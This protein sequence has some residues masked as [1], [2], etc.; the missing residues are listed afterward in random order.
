MLL[1]L[2][3]DAGIDVCVVGE[4]ALNYYNVPRIIHVGH[5]NRS[6]RH[7]LT[8][9]AIKDLELC[10][11][12]SHLATATAIFESA[13][14]LLE[15]VVEK[16]DD[17]AY[18][19]Y[20]EYKRGFPR[21]RFSSGAASY[22]VVLFTDKYCHLDPLRKNV[23]S[24]NGHRKPARYSQE[25]LDSL[26]PDQVALLPFPRFDPFFKGLCRTYIAT[27][28][29]TAAIAA[30]LLVDG[31]DIDEDWCHH[32]LSPSENGELSFALRLV[33]GKGSRIADFSLNKVTCFIPDRQEARRVQKI[34]GFQ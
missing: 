1:G 26:L 6:S 15:K 33:R 5:D 27:L 3:Q 34:P 29:V 28:E 11:P 18:N 9:F 31:M 21:F 12:A 14:G 8:G 24:C 10:V 16:V 2:L 17:V 4:V 19:I 23:V 32:H 30:E 20:T 7:M 13:Q 25:I 22:H